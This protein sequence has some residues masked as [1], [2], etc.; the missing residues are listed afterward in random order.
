MGIVQPGLGRLVQLLID[1][2]VGTRHSRT[3]EID[4]DRA[5]VRRTTRRLPGLPAERNA[6]EGKEAD[7]HRQDS[8]NRELSPRQKLHEKTSDPL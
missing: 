8:D 4:A 1:P 6:T 2:E 3:G 7:H 5:G